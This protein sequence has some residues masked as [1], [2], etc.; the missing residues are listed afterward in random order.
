M[1]A[2]RNISGS[3][4][5][6]RPT[7]GAMLQAS[8]VALQSGSLIKAEILIQQLLK[9]DPRNAE[10]IHL[11]GITRIEQKRFPEAEQC[12]RKAVAINRNPTYFII[13]GLA[14]AS[15]G[16]DAQARDAYQ[17]GIALEPQA[18]RV[19]NNLG[20]ILD[21]MQDRAGAELNYRRALATDPRYC[22][23]H[24]NLGILLRETGRPHESETSFRQAL[25][26]EPETGAIWST[27]A[28][29]LDSLNRLDDAEAAYRQA[30]RWDSVQHV[31]RQAA[32]WDGL[33][34][35][36]AAAIELVESAR[37]A[38][39]GTWEL[40]GIPSM[41]PAV[42]REAGR[43]FALSRWGRELNAQGASAATPREADG[44][45]LKIGYLSSDFYDHATMHLLAGVLELHDQSCVDVHLY[46]YGPS[47]DDAF[48]S[49]IANMPATFHDVAAATDAEAATQIAAD[50]IQLLVDLKGFTTG[51][52]LGISARRPAP[53]TLNWLGYPGSLG[54][55]GLADYLIGDPVVTPP[56]H[57]DHFSETLALM[58]HCYQP[59]DHRRE[60]GP[61]P[62]HAEAGLPETGIVF[63]SF[64]QTF[65]FGPTMFSVWCR[66]LAAVPGSVL[67]LLEPPVPD[68][69]DNL[70]K[71]ATA[72]GIDASRLIFADRLKQPAH[73]ARLALA[74]IALDTFPCNSHTTG[75]DALWAGVPM[76]TRSGALFA[77]RV[78]ASLLRAAGLGELV[79]ED[80]ET[81]FN[82]ALSLASDPE[83]LAALS[84]QLIQRRETLPLF[85]TAQFTRD[86][87]RLYK[88]IWQRE[89]SGEAGT[90]APIVL[91]AE[92]RE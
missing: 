66:L 38:N 11:L 29:L 56:A 67:W 7:V 10:A 9:R 57:A 53:V 79:T 69:I 58:P 24:R 34:E 17:A 23:A 43:L 89:T 1:S 45:R 59:N 88:A 74:D 70:R 62:T 35:I 39:P 22:L 40:L 81:Y 20:T 85:N 49:R 36:D 72:R 18:A 32:S 12:L 4:T 80:D 54:H 47:R 87:E 28:D 82:V 65:Q 52:R 2:T 76:V 50:G 15:Q 16:K 33:D 55:S 48:T 60:S 21:R 83:R 51:T 30:G 44:H 77:S 6:G 37:F 27:Y 14:L 13:L 42:H 19:Y 73:L 31:M 75:S 61:Q 86:L 25:A 71:E 91:S 46:S 64:N 8:T 26:I 84:T 3:R 92:E 78:G 41:P 5:A 68:V 90:K 63:C